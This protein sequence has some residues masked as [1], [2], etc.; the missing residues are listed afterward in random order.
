MVFTIS[1]EKQTVVVTGGNRGLG[2]AISQQLAAAG[3]NIVM[4]YRSSKDAPERAKELES[5]YGVK[6]HAWQCDVGDEDKVIQTFKEIGDHPEFGNITGV[7]A[8]AGVSVVKP[9][10]ELTKEDFRYVYDTNV[11]G[12]FNVSKAA[13]KIFIEKQTKG[14]IV[15]ISSMSSQI[16]NQG[17][18]GKPLTQIFYNSS[19]SAVSGLMKCMAMEWI[20]HGIRVNAVCPGFINTE[21]TSGMPQEMRDFQAKGVPVGRFSEPVEQTAQ[22]LLLLS[23][24]SAY[25]TGTEYFVD[26]GFLGY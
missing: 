10:L 20:E 26:G 24:H 9:A 6:A 19:K 22:V 1:F 25:Q 15:I 7:V 11:L 12:V 5:K 2:W 16:C 4:I 3:A 21:Q 23:P 13:A 14:S 8:N 17:A 18:L